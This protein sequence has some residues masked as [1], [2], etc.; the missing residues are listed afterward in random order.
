M[1]LPLC[2]IPFPLSGARDF[3]RMLPEWS[4]SPEQIAHWF[5]VHRTTSVVQVMCAT[6]AFLLLFWFASALAE[7]ISP[8]G[9]P[10]TASRVLVPAAAAFSGGYLVADSSWL[11][12]ALQGTASHPADLT[13]TRWEFEASSVTMMLSQPFIALFLTAVGV[14][15][16][17]TGAL[18]R[19]TAWGSFAVTA[20]NFTATFT[21]L[22]PDGWAAPLSLATV[23]PYGL[24][25]LWLVV[26]GCAVLLTP[27]T[28]HAGRT[29]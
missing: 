27:G 16:L 4:Q 29:A 18:P 14:G 23:A 8:P 22:V 24:F 20:A 3:P 11:M 10:T 15:V 21:I 1:F 2:V 5:A 26:L 28:A 17:Q 9:A 6:V 7:L 25:A 13:T 19:W 12:L